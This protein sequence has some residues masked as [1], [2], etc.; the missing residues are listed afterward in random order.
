MHRY[1]LCEGGIDLFHRKHAVISNPM[2]LFSV[3]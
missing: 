2:H 3:T 1:I